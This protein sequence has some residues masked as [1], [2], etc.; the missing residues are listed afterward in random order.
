MY[1]SSK[2][3][4]Q[5]SQAII[6]KLNTFIPTDEKILAVLRI[7]NVFPTLETAVIT[8]KRL[9][10]VK[11]DFSSTKNITFAKELSGVDITC[12]TTGKQNR[13]MIYIPLMITNK[14][15]KTTKFADVHKNDIEEAVSVSQTVIG[16]SSQIS[17]LEL[18][19]KAKVEQKEAAKRQYQIQQDNEAKRNGG[20]YDPLGLYEKNKYDYK[21]LTDTSRSRLQRKVEKYLKDGYELEGGIVH[22]SGVFLTR[23][24][25]WSQSVSR[26]R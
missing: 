4:Q 3:K 1:V 25:R 19:E 12:I 7:T 10:G 8:D 5:L 9:I 23:G 15:G 14:D 22:S 24:Q 20:V 26:R 6:E 13:L 11:T 16:K 21:V 17:V 18:Q 2:V